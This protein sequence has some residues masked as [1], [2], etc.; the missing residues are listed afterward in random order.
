MWE[1][2]GVR[3]RRAGEGKK[4]HTSTADRGK[5]GGAETS[6]GQPDVA[7]SNLNREERK[8]NRKE[9]RGDLTEKGRGR[10]REGAA[11]ERTKGAAGE[12]E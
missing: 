10:R 6:K 12:R 11:G 2:K 3:K 7:P 9:P 8:S 5:G 1:P 4:V